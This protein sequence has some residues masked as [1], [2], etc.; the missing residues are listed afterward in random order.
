MEVSIQPSTSSVILYPEAVQECGSRIRG[1]VEFA[2]KNACEVIDLRFRI[3]GRKQIAKDVCKALEYENDQ[4]SKQFPQT[5][6]LR[7]IKLLNI[8][9]GQEI[10]LADIKTLSKG[11]HIFAFDSKI[12]SSLPGSH[13]HSLSKVEYELILH[14]RGRP[15]GNFF[16]L[17]FM[18]TKSIPLII[19]VHPSLA[20]DKGLNNFHRLL[21]SQRNDEDIKLL[22][23]S[24]NSRYGGCIDLSILQRVQEERIKMTNIN[25]ELRQAMSFRGEEITGMEK[26]CSIGDMKSIRSEKISQEKVIF[27]DQYSIISNSS[28]CKS[29]GHAESFEEPVQ[30]TEIKAWFPETRQI[31]DSATPSNYQTSLSGW[32]CSTPLGTDDEIRFSHSMKALITFT[33]THGQ[34]RQLVFESPL[35][36]VDQDFCT[37]A[38]Q[39]PDYASA[40]GCRK[41]STCIP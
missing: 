38:L 17:P 13:D 40:I 15:K 35:M 4:A 34:E 2:I 32:H 14:I 20:G 36:L 39:L 26:Q 29:A 33:S 12:P 18:F 6:F 27:D 16:K 5:I 11:T 21:N 30:R 25:I 19:K 10:D 9:N 22:V 24:N 7:D 37:A 1:Y 3:L 23:H 41:E 8:H 28:T 31:I